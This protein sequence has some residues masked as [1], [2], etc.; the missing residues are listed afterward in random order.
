MQR[1]S[2]SEDDDEADGVGAQSGQEVGQRQAVAIADDLSVTV[3]A[4]EQHRV[5]DVTLKPG[6]AHGQYSHKW[7]PTDQAM[8]LRAMYLLS[9]CIFFEAPRNALDAGN[10]MNQI[11]SC[12]FQ[13]I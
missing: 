4:I 9:T 12:S 11:F 10:E 7:R 5:L 6:H 2:L 3:V 13:N 1:D 8:S